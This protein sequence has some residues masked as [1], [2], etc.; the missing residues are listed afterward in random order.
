MIPVVL[1]GNAG[2]WTGDAWAGHDLGHMSLIGLRGFADVSDVGF[3]DW[4][5]IR[6]DFQVWSGPFWMRA[7]IQTEAQM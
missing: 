3:E 1:T 4:K 7:G 5:G 6:D 2:V